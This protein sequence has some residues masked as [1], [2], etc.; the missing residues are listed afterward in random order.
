MVSL[1]MAIFL[2]SNI[3]LIQSIPELAIL[4]FKIP[5]QQLQLLGLCPMDQGAHN[6]LMEK[7]MFFIK[8][9]VKTANGKQES[10]WIMSIGDLFEKLSSNLWKFYNQQIITFQMAFSFVNIRPPHCQGYY[11]ALVFDWWCT[12]ICKSAHMLDINFKFYLVLGSNI[13]WAWNWSHR[14]IS[15]RFRFAVRKNKCILQWSNR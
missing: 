12:I 1:E 9:F 15:W 2:L 13:R 7:K 8:I 6:T 3:W 10:S 11:W 4:K 14:Y 5:W